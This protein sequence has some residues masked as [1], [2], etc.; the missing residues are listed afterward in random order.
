MKTPKMGTLCLLAAGLLISGK[1][2][3]QEGSWLVQDV[4]DG[5]RMVLGFKSVRQDGSA[6][7]EAKPARLAGIQC[8]SPGQRFFAYS[9]AFTEVALGGR[10]KRAKVKVLMRG[11]L[12][13]EWEPS[14]RWEA[15]R[16]PIGLLLAC[17]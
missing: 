13:C 1:I 6:A 9:K 16:L 3:A 10:F 12:N 4:S 11:R 8:P 2:A 5:D 7:I 15:L 14:Y 17:P